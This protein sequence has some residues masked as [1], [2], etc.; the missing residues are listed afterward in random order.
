MN[1]PDHLDLDHFTAAPQRRIGSQA[2]IRDEKGGILLFESRRRV[3]R[4][5]VLT[6]NLPGGCARGGEDPQAACRRR[7]QEKSGLLIEPGK[8]LVMHWQPPKDGTVEGHNYVW[9][10]GVISSHT[11]CQLATD[12]V[13][14]YR[15][16]PRKQLTAFARDSLVE[17]IDAA[18]G[19]G[20]NGYLAGHAG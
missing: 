1:S 3:E 20:H 8:L 19:R 12:E 9:D 17:R 2:L 13:T 18:L 15:F 14:Q 5:D 16:V 7:I 4:G 11:E 6:W 10:G